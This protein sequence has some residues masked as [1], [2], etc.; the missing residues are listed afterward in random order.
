MEHSRHD[1]MKGALLERRGLV[2][3]VVDENYP[4]ALALDFAGA[5]FYSMGLVLQ[6]YA[7]SY[8]SPAG[9]E[10]RVSVCGCHM[11]RGGAWCLGLL[12]YGSGN[13]IYTIAM[14]FAPVSLLTT[15]FAVA[16]V[17]NAALSRLVMR[18]SIDGRGA[19]GY[20]LI[21]V[22]IAVS[23]VGLPKETAAFSADDMVALA[24][25]PAGIAYLVAMAA[26][27]ATLGLF[28]HRFEK[29]FPLPASVVT[30]ARPS[31]SP[32]PASP[33][34]GGVEGI[35]A[36]Q[37]FLAQVCFP[38]VLSSY[39]TLAQLCIKGASS[40]LLVSTTEHG[41]QMGEPM[42]WIVVALGFATT[43]QAVLWLRKVYRRFDTSTTLPIEYASLTIST[44]FGGILWF[45]EHEQLE[46]SDWVWVLV[47]EA[48]LV[49]GMAG[50]AV[51]K[52]RQRLRE[53][54]AAPP[55]ADADAAAGAGSG[56][57]SG[58][59]SGGQVA[60]TVSGVSEPEE[61]DLRVISVPG[62]AAED[63]GQGQGQAADQEQKLVP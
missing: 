7:L 32:A 33:P 3:D 8:P 6:R 35:P 57:G 14:Q 55:D 5:C 54:Q 61:I 45:E 19:V 10:G 29:Q 17:M 22:G 25:R 48:V 15:V 36:R 59:G 60:A 26:I 38:S 27:I 49:V 23:S 12:T 2:D 62:A 42:F 9:H 41:S 53:L 20:L 31:P 4:L 37:L 34:R 63:Q 47:G 21:L 40:M 1:E 44:S 56:A 58:S 16:L 43:L 18:E 52:H 30:A 13:G 11:R 39:E 50:V 46:A 24:A 51:A 28:V